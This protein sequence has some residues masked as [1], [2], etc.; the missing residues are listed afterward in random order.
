[1]RAPNLTVSPRQARAFLRVRHALG[2][3]FARVVD[4]VSHLGYVQLDPINVCGRMHDL[5]LRNRVKG[6]A[7]GVLL[8]HLHG[9]GSG[10]RGGFEHYLPGKGILVAF[11]MEAWPYVVAFIGARGGGPHYYGRPLSAAE[12][13]L[14]GHIMDRIKVDGSITSDAIEHEARSETV[15]GTSGRMAKTVLEALFASGRVLISGR[16]GFRRVYDLPERV[17][18]ASVLSLPGPGPAELAGWL[19]ML[20]LRQHRLARLR[21]TDVDAL[22]KSIQPVRVDGGSPVY[23]LRED[24][25]ALVSSIDLEPPDDVRLLAPLDPMI[26]DRELTRRLWDFDYTW[27]VYTPKAVR[28]RGYYALPVLS[29]GELVGHVEP[30]ADRKS[31]TLKVVSRRVRRVH[32]TAHAVRGLA[33]FLNLR[34]PG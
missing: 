1:M 10:V 3:E 29:K 13:E 16:T 4:A 12:L 11:P 27:E 2:P 34:P 28:R 21:K 5:I 23:C 33:R 26:Y 25:G 8:R 17:I 6:Y 30:V 15:W 7:E 31:R 14:A 20:K 19:V 18:P 9:E 32:A 24:V 22:A